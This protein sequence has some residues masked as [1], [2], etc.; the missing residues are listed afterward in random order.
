MT[1][2]DGIKNM[3]KSAGTMVSEDL[4]DILK[5]KKLDSISLILLDILIPFK[6]FSTVLLSISEPL[7]GILFGEAAAEKIGVFASGE[8]S[9]EDLKE[10]LERGRK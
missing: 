9:L 5:L 2:F 1:A 10:A 6:R 8:N 3:E 7:A 4:A